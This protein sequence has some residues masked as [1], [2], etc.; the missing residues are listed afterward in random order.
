[1]SLSTTTTATYELVK[2]SRA[3][4]QSSATQNQVSSELD[5]QHFSNPVIRLTMDTRKAPGGTLEAYRLR[6]TWALN[7]SLDAMDVDQREVLFVRPL[8]YFAPWI[9][10]EHVFRPVIQEDLDLVAYSSVS[11]FQ[12]L[13]NM[14]IK[15][16]YRGSVV[17]LRY[18]YPRVT[19]PGQ[20]PVSL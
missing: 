9:H 17:G 15:A 19:S 18:Q 20:T 11:N 4:N 3:Y 7:P 5:W 6:I 14:P 13:N 1:M 2:Y 10:K 12:A 8:L 16:V